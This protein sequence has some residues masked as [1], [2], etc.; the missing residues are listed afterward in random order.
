MGLFRGWFS[1]V[2]TGSSSELLARD[3]GHVPVPAA[4]LGA[5]LSLL[6]LIGSGKLLDFLVAST[7]AR[8]R[9]RSPAPPAG[10]RNPESGCWELG[11][12][13][14]ASLHTAY[15]QGT[16]SCYLGQVLRLQYLECSCETSFPQSPP[17]PALLC[18]CQPWG[19]GTEKRDRRRGLR[20]GARLE[21][22]Q[23]QP[24]QVIDGLHRE[25]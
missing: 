1:P 8:K 6:S 7:L 19:K 21:A 4:C 11:F 3:S 17:P 15:R 24:S 10:P 13:T 14:P 16:A 18:V 23:L 20:A 2:P 12:R 9:N 22:C 25:V 5:E